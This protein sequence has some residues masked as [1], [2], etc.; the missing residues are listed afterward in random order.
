MKRESIKSRRP[1][2]HQLTTPRTESHATAE[3]Q[4]SQEVC[5]YTSLHGMWPV[6]QTRELQFSDYQASILYRGRL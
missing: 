6:P 2:Q 1:Y 5:G 3:L 4:E